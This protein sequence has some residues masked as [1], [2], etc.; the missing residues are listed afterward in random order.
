MYREKRSSFACTMSGLLLVV[1]SLLV[2]TDV[3]GQGWTSRVGKGASSSSKPTNPVKPAA[4]SKP[5]GAGKA[6]QNKSGA[7]SSGHQKG[8]APAASTTT[9]TVPGKGSR[10]R[11]VTDPNTSATTPAAG[12][13]GK[14]VATPYAKTGRCDPDKDERVDL[15]GTYNGSLNYPAA[16]M[17]GDA[18]LTINGNRFTLNSG[19]KTE[20]GN[21]TAVTTCNYTAVA[22]M[23][24]QW[25]T[26]Q[27]GEP[28][29]PPLP[30]L[31]LKATK[32]GD[33]LVLKTSPSERREFSFEP[34]ARK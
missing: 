33:Q 16:A 22:M 2:G 9:G 15:S 14:S 12:S 24:G 17:I 3:S 26:P 20:M 11:R 8:T 5:Y 23:F 31:S 10:E 29:L 28:V 27:P 18:T 32:K 7:A 19:S 30:M 34:S 6:R 4:T 13:E 1:F 25:K 21:I